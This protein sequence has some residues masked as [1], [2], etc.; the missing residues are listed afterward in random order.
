M[1]GFSWGYCSPNHFQTNDPLCKSR[2]F[3]GL[4]LHEMPE[5]EL[6]YFENTFLMEIEL[7]WSHIHLIL[8]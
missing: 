7:N 4:F 3:Q 8:I 6:S 5:C 1:L 2:C